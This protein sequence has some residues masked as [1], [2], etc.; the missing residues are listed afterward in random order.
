MRWHNLNA[1]A[2]PWRRARR[3]DLWR[4]ARLFKHKAYLAQLVECKPLNV[5]V[6][7]SSSTVCVQY[8]LS[9]VTDLFFLLSRFFVYVTDLS[10]KIYFSSSFLLDS[11]GTIRPLN[12]GASLK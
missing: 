6:V 4:R 5:V 9:F 11:F 1:V 12:R 7:G 3:Q 8:F 2:P 10:V